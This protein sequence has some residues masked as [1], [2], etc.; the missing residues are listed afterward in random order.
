MSR[1]AK[2]IA[3][4]VGALVTACFGFTAG[5]PAQQTTGKTDSIP[6]LIQNLGSDD[7]PTREAAMAELVKLDEAIRA[8]DQALKSE[9]AEVTNRAQQL[10][11]L[12]YKRQGTGARDDGASGTWP[13]TRYVVPPQKELPTVQASGRVTRGATCSGGPGQRIQSR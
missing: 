2:V 12:F 13:A 7:F 5:T 8:L 1:R 11:H 3:L 10:I 9:D 6:Q 4:L